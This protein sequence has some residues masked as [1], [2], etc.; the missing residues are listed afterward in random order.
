MKIRDARVIAGW[1]D[2]DGKA[3]TVYELCGVN[4]VLYLIVRGAGENS[5]VLNNYRVYRVRNERAWDLLTGQ[6]LS[7]R[8]A[9]EL[10]DGRIIASRAGLLEIREN[11]PIKEVAK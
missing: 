11:F 4:K 2:G 1:L 3:T 8:K 6:E 9:R 10:G 5:V 7:L